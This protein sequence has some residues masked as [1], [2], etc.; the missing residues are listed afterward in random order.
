MKN[1]IFTGMPASGKTTFGKLLAEKLNEYAFVDTDDVIVKKQGCSICEIFEFKGEEYF[2][3]TETEVL[4]E[5]LSSENKIVSTGGGIVLKEENRSLL[6]NNSIV[7]YLKTDV[8]TLCERAK[9]TQDRPLLNVE[10]TEKKIISLLK[11]RETFYK[12]TSDIIINTTGKTKDEIIAEITENLKI[13]M[14]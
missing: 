1:I 12:C 3:T 2:R 14:P 11:Q 4:K 8:E 13:Y 5:I 10:E 7:I 6:N 9:K